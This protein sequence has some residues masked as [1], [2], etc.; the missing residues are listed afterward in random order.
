VKRRLC[1]LDRGTLFRGPDGLLW[2][3]GYPVTGATRW[4]HAVGRPRDSTLLS[5]DAE[6]EVVDPAAVLARAAE[7][8]RENAELRAVLHDLWQDRTAARVGAEAERGAVLTFVR[9]ILKAEQGRAGEPTDY[10]RGWRE[11]AVNVLGALLPALEALGPWRPPVPPCALEGA[12]REAV[13]LL[14]EA[15]VS[16]PG[17]GVIGYGWVKVEAALA[18]LRAAVEPDG[19]VGR[20]DR[21]LGEG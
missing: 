1:D 21:S 5:A 15:A 19:P 18:R 14:T 9:S 11:G 2:R 10:G 3:P 6:V 4:C 12:V 7:L 20:L 16:V 13:G 17:R 8:E